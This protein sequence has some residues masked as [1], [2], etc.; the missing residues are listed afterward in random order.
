M[1]LLLIQAES[2]YKCVL[3]VGWYLDDGAVSGIETCS[4]MVS[5][6]LG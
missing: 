4:G 6:A 3:Q 1:I 5:C 2:E